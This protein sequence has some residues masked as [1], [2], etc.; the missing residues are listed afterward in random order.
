MSGS[1]PS[2][3][4][5][6]A[7]PPPA[8]PPVPH[9]QQRPHP[10]LPFFVLRSLSTVGFT[11]EATVRCRG[12][13]HSGRSGRLGPSEPAAPRGF[14]LP[15]R[16]RAPLLPPPAAALRQALP[17]GGPGLQ[18]KLTRG[19]PGC[20]R[21]R[22]RAP[23]PPHAA[24]PSGGGRTGTRAFL[25][26]KETWGLRAQGQMLQEGAGGPPHLHSHTQRASRTCHLAVPLPGLP[27]ERNASL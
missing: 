23:P 1:Q 15:G 18:E 11:Q 12:G 21:V 3:L 6:A 27:G 8:R 2:P 5:S 10:L 16:R 25:R 26:G 14:P 7:A 17:L 9:P 4:T 19:F 13:P 20:R 24:G 22:A